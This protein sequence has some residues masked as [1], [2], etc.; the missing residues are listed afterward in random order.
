[1]GNF[2]KRISGKILNQCSSNSVCKV[3]YM[4]GIKYVNLIEVGPVI[5][6]I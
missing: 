6:E 5:I 2:Q 4:K 3:M 1:M